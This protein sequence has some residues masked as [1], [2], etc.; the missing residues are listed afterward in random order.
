MWPRIILILAGGLIAASGLVVSKMANAKDLIAKITPFQ[1]FIGVG[2]LAYGVY[3]VITAHSLATMPGISM[4]FKLTIIGWFAGS[5]LLGIL[6]G[7]PQI[8]TWTG[9]KGAAAEKGQEFAKKIAP[10]Q[11]LIGVVGL[12][13]GALLLLFQLNIL[14]IIDVSAAMG[15]G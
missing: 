12:A 5:I 9:G 13:V 1:G 7:M 11:T 8:M 4:L 15:A 2:L 3:D 14:H 10:Y 6:L